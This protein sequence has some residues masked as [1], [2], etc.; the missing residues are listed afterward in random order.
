MSVKL[1]DGPGGF[2]LLVFP[3][4]YSPYV[5]VQRV[6][7]DLGIQGVQRD[8]LLQVSVHKHH[9]AAL[10]GRGRP[11]VTH[12]PTFPL[13]EERDGEREVEKK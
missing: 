1:L 11:I 4:V 13:G 2:G 5:C 12:S 6:P 3:H 9:R 10:G 7:L 8:V